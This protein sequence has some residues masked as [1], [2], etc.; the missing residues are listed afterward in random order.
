[1]RY[2]RGCWNRQTGT[3]E[4]RVSNGVGVQVP[5][6]AP[7]IESRHSPTLY[8]LCSVGG[9]RTRKDRCA[10][11]SQSFALVESRTRRNSA[12]NRF[13]SL[14]NGVLLLRSWYTRS[15]TEPQKRLC[16][17]TGFA[18]RIF[19]KYHCAAQPGFKVPRAVGS[20]SA[21]WQKLGAN[22]FRPRVSDIP[23]CFFVLF[24]L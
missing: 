8:F 6:L 4:V 11:F 23:P 24:P 9:R 3:F 15:E 10:V 18:C 17:F 22:R 7:K 1:M 13:K 2:M 12:Q 21:N 20:A 14:C 19:D 5:S 16:R